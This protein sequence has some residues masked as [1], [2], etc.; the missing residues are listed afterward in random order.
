[1]PRLRVL[2]KEQATSQI[3][4]N[5]S[6]MLQKKLAKQ[7]DTIEGALEIDDEYFNNVFDTYTKAVDEK[8]Q[9][10]DDFVDELAAMA[11]ENPSFLKP[12]YRLYAKTNGEIDSMHKLNQYLSN[13]LG[14]LRK[15]IVDQN[16]EVPSLL[17]RELQ[18]TR[19]ANMIN[20]TAPATAWVGNLSAVAIRPLTTLAGSVPIGFATGNWK[21]CRGHWLLL[22][23]CKK[24]SV[25]LVRWHEMNG[26]LSTVALKLLWHVVVQTM[27]LVI[28]TQMPPQ[29]LLITKRWKHCPRR[30]VLDV[31]HC[32]TLL[33]G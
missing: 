10:I 2:L 9:L 28:L 29:P 22:V 26:S 20:G 25:V 5:M 31:R 4:E 32:G 18:A 24:P 14:V 12:V 1:M 6:T 33:N 7:A 16:P 13:N 30:L 23:N 17:L 11:K 3:S 27:T 8:A 19:T 15:G 21:N